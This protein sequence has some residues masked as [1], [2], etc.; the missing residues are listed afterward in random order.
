MEE[1]FSKFTQKG[2]PG[3]PNELKAFTE[4]FITS[5]EGQWAYPG[6]NTLI[7]NAGGRITMQ[8]VNYPVLGIDDLGNEMMM[9]PGEEYQFPGDSVYEIPMKKG[10]LVK[11]PKLTKKN[12]KSYDKKFS[13]SIDATSRLF[14]ESPLFTKPKSKKRKVFDPNSQYQDGGIVQLDGYRF[15]KDANG[16]WIYESGAPVTDKGMIQRLTY[17]AKPVGSPVV[18]SAPKGSLK[19]IPTRSENLKMVSN[20]SMSPRIADQE[21]AAQLSELQ[22]EQDIFNPQEPDMIMKPKNMN[23]LKGYEFQV[24]RALGF[25]MDKA[26]F[27]AEAAA[28][29]VNEEVDNFRHPLAG[30][31]VAEGIADA[32]GNIPYISPALGF[33]GSNLLGA[34]HEFMTLVNPGEDDRSLLTRLSESGEDLYNNYVGAKVGASDMTPEEKTN[35]LLYLSYNNKLPDGVVIEKDPKAKGPNNLYFKKGPNDPGKYKSS[36]DDGGEYEEAEL[37]DEE[38]EEYRKGGWVVEEIEEYD[39]GGGV[40]FQSYEQQLRQLENSVKAGYRGG[41]WYPHDSVEKGRQTIGYGHKLSGKENYSKGLTTAQVL[42]LQKK[43]LVKHTNI[44]KT[45]VDN[46]YGA[47]TFDRL[48][49]SRKVLLV[50][51]AYNGVLHEFPNFMKATV[52]GDKAGMLK[53]YKRYTGSKPLTQRNEWTRSVIEGSNT[54]SKPVSTPKSLPAKTAPKKTVSKAA[55]AAKPKFTSNETFSYDYRPDAVYRVADSGDWYINAGKDTHNEFIK[56]NDPTG[57]RT[58]TLRKFAHINEVP[59]DQIL[60]RINNSG[61]Y[62]SRIDLGYV[63]G[64]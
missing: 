4:G 52:K 55:P 21:K 49:E 58:E 7:P 44:A 54:Q 19:P 20:L 23:D 63:P 43:D 14:T 60:N 45:M 38:I 8:G 32:T 18:Q 1:Y 39:N 48:P 3:G 2:L 37:T 28:G 36:Y 50:D 25:P 15:K 10:G 13:R 57:K 42:A 31:Y 16:N 34:G 30:R 47:G 56:L 6:M 11:M 40:N 17:E 46:K 12:K 51:Y 5:S 27:A 41:K 59:L 62:D 64:Q 33:I 24:N 22:R 53:E 61:N 29:D 35:Y 9:Q 26:H